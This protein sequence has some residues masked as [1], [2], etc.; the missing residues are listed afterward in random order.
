VDDA[1]WIVERLGDPTVALVDVR[2]LGFE[3]V[4]LYDGSWA[5]WSAREDLPQERG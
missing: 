3:D 4:R 1:A 2:T 5:E